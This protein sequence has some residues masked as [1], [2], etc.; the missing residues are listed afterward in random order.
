VCGAEAM[1]GHTSPTTHAS[2]L[3][4]ETFL[5]DEPTG[6]ISWQ[7]SDA[8]LPLPLCWI[9]LERRGRLFA[10]H[11]TTVV[12]GAELGI[13]TILDF[14]DVIAMLGNADTASLS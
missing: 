8:T 7:T 10:Y 12:I 14:S 9:P 3:R 4:A 1:Q 6:W 2:H 13:I 5:W 11:G